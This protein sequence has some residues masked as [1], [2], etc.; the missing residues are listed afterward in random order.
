[1][2][3]VNPDRLERIN[4][5][6][7]NVIAAASNGDVLPLTVFA[8]LFALALTQIRAAGRQVVVALFDAVAEALLVIIAPTKSL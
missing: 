6:A 3:G 5:L 7:S 4:R 8:V 1:M 2:T